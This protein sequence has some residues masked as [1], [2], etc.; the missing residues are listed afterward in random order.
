MKQN[1]TASR[2]KEIALPI[3]SEKGYEGA[4]LSEIAAGVGIKKPSIYAH[5]ANKEA[6]FLAVVED[7]TEAYINHWQEIQNS[8]CDQSVE[9]RLYTLFV[10][11]V[12][13]FGQ[14]PL[15]VALWVRVWM[16]PP[17]KLKEQLV[18]KMKLV[19][20]RLAL[21]VSAI[22]QCGLDQRVTRSG[23]E[24]DMAIAYLSLLNGYLMRVICYGDID[25]ERQ[26]PII[27]HY[28]WS[29]IDKR[30]AGKGTN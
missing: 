21:D 8:T 25:Y 26:A 13:Y 30:Y 23:E 5:Y 14:N 17:A 22:L 16:F 11:T 12:R 20:R 4:A 6:L 28:F 15:K 3:F 7:M 9:E 27:W 29:G 2:I 19:H 24:E 18:Q 1:M 10:E